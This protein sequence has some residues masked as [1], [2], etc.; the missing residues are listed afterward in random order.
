MMRSS[1]PK[2]ADSAESQRISSGIHAMIITATID[3]AGQA[4]RMC[5]G[6][7]QS[8]G[9]ASMLAVGQGDVTAELNTLTNNPPHLLVGTPQKILDLLSMRSVAVDRMTLLVIDEMDQLIARNLSEYVN[10]VAKL[11]PAPVTGPGSGSRDRSI[12]PIG[13]A[14]NATA[15]SPTRPDNDRQTAIFSCTVP[16]EVLN[17]AS[18]LNLR[19]PVRV[20]VRREN[21]QDNGPANSQAPN[22]RGMK[23]FF[24]YLAVSGTGSG[25]PGH[26]DGRQMTSPGVREWKLEALADLCADADFTQAVVFCS[27]L[28]SVDAVQY[29]LMSRSIEAFVLHSDMGPAARNTVISKFRSANGRGVGIKRVLVVYD[30]LCRTLSDIH[31]VA[32]VVNYDLPRSVEDYVHRCVV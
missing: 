5:L 19:E 1:T 16:Q 27:S 17:F 32:L 9:I 2:M 7:G 6:L 13:R 22:L 12:R 30:A 26:I 11:L 25:G 4:H 21:N 8:L 15:S 24:L 14:D 10:N 31:Q 20:L 3:Q 28:D 23:H 29:K 18:A